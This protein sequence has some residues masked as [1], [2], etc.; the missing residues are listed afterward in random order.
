MCK[1]EKALGR[2]GFNF[3]TLFPPI[4]WWGFSW[5]LEEI[6]EKRGRERREWEYE[7]CEV[8][9]DHLRFLEAVTAAAE[10]VKNVTGEEP[11]T[12][13]FFSIPG[14]G[15]LNLGCAMKI[16]NNGNTYVFYRSAE[17]LKEIRSAWHL[18]GRWSELNQVQMSVDYLGEKEK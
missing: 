11:H 6:M 12:I 8:C 10:V 15:E 18:Q 13:R 3:F 5:G 7:E 16:S 17:V 9:D 14:D 4:D 2:E 1:R